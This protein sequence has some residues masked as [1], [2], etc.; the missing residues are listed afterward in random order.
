MCRRTSG[1]IEINNAKRRIRSTEHVFEFD[2]NACVYITCKYMVPD[3]SERMKLVTIKFKEQHPFI[4]H[5]PDILPPSSS[6]D[7]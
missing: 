6:N 5:Y 4:E 1:D 2:S 7:F 3:L